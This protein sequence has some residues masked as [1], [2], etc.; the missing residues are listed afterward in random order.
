VNI[1]FGSSTNVIIS[2]IDAKTLA[3][4]VSTGSSLFLDIQSV[5]RPFH[6][7]ETL[8]SSKIKSPRYSLFG[9]QIETTFGF[10]ILNTTPNVNMKNIPLSALPTFYGKNSEDPDTFL[11][12]F[13]ILRRRYNYVQDAQK[14]KLFPATLK[15]STLRWFMGLGESSIRSWEA[16][17]DIFLKK[18]QD[19]C[20]T[21]ESRNDIFK[22]QQLEDETLEYYMERFG[23]ISQKSKYHDLPKDAIRALFLKVISEEY[24]EMLNLMA[25][26]DIS[27]NPFAEIC[28]MCKNYSRSRAKTWKNV[29]DPYNRNLKSVSSGGITREEIGNLLENFKT[30][31]LSTIGSQLNTL[32]KKRNR[33]R[34]MQQ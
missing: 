22:I 14:I 20:K 27:H 3:P 24:L 7:R 15:D 9:N 33:R 2:Q 23:Y 8:F 16:M 6:Q 5:G 26:S 31:I 11:F 25:S 18:Y 32:K 13:D 34:K 30:D 12:E 1:L 17:K 4:I 10:P 19:Y 28:E 29:W 21:K